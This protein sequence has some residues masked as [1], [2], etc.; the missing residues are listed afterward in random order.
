[1]TVLYGS[2]GSVLFI[3]RFSYLVHDCDRLNKYNWNK[4]LINI[5]IVLFAYSNSIVIS[6]N[7]AKTQ[8]FPNFSTEFTVIISSKFKVHLQFK[9]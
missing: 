9:C 2:I 1:M 5:K 4:K 3:E 7:K 8:Q 6:Y